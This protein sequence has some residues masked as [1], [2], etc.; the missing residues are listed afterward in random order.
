MNQVQNSLD[1]IPQTYVRFHSR[2]AVL[3][4]F[5]A[6]GTAI[7]VFVPSCI[8][9]ETGA[10]IRLLV[11]VEGLEE[12][13]SLSGTVAWK[14]DSFAGNE[15]EPGFGMHIS[16]EEKDPAVRLLAMCA[17]RPAEQGTAQEKRYPSGLRC[18]V[19]HGVH[20]SDARLCDLSAS[21]AFVN[22]SRLTPI[23]EGN[24]ITLRLNTGILGFG[25]AVLKAKVVWRGKKGNKPGFGAR[26]VGNPAEIRQALRKQLRGNQGR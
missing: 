25:N 13:F 17:N 1:D 14:R 9:V 2:R 20:C 18:T 8:P 22:M 6:E 4:S 21:G 19:I 26:F 24:E 12:S 5:R 10:K 23:R 15:R 11:T 3:S 16:P 7:T